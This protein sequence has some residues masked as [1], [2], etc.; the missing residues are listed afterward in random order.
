MRSTLYIS[1]EALKFSAAHMTVFPDGTKE[2]LHGHNFYVSVKV[3]LKD[4]SFGS[5]I[6]FNL[7]K[8]ALKPLCD[9][10]DEKILL[11][12]KNPFLQASIRGESLDFT[13][14]GKHYIFPV[15]EVIVLDLDNIS[16]ESLAKELLTKLLISLKPMTVVH[17]TGVADVNRPLLENIAL[18]E[19]QIDES[20]G[21]GASCTYCS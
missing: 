8:K 11:Q 2:G 17:N 16:S 1:K 21:Q 6:D 4:D 5:M 9:A 20:N 15:E 19:L 10:W 13:L 7:F 18:I 3:E 14:C 12:G